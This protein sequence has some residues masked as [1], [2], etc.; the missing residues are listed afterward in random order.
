MQSTS[1]STK[2]AL[3]FTPG[4]WQNQQAAAA[5]REAAQQYARENL[6]LDF[7]DAPHWRTLAAAAGIR[8]PAWYVRCTPGGLRKQSVRLGLDLTAIEDVTGCSSYR[9]LAGLNPTWPLFAVVG[10][11][12]EIAA[13]RTPATTH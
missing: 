3:L 9:E 5:A 13:E 7:A 2:A 1:T 8:L 6:R 10:L 4:H 12:L 11:L